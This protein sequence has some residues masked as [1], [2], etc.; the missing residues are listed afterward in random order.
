MLQS[1]V[2]NVSDEEDDTWGIWTAQGNSHRHN[3]IARRVQVLLGSGYKCF[4]QA[5][6]QA[7]R[8]IDDHNWL[9]KS[10]LDKIKAESKL[11]K[12]KAEQKVSDEEDDTWKK[13]TAQGNSQWASTTSAATEHNTHHTHLAAV[14]LDAAMERTAPSSYAAARTKA[15]F[16]N[17]KQ[18][19]IDVT[20]VPLTRCALARRSAR[21][22]GKKQR[23]GGL[24][25]TSI[26]SIS[27][28]VAAYHRAANGAEH[29]ECDGIVDN[30][31][32][33][34]HTLFMRTDVPDQLVKLLH[35]WIENRSIN[36]ALR[37][38]LD[39]CLAERSFWKFFNSE[40]RARAVHLVGTA[41]EI[42]RMNGD[43]LH[44]RVDNC[45][46]NIL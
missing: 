20:F 43:E 34:A 29:D 28:C 9:Q 30:I 32:A 38:S 7:E 1:M 3:K 19:V 27:R 26:E 39:R 31:G 22:P 18:N 6:C 12:I 15:W 16:N 10:E 33:Y 14:I 13:W 25:P 44:R 8:M 46:R 36:M 37:L 45:G 5:R 11:D 42:V 2:Q 41:I 21:P 40:D 4:S 35:Q 24:W 17:L 23:K